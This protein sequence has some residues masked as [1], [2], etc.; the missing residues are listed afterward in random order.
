M[1]VVFWFVTGVTVFCQPPEQIKKRE[2][3]VW[4][5]WGDGTIEVWIWSVWYEMKYDV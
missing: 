5:R 1:G 2:N 3:E 4:M